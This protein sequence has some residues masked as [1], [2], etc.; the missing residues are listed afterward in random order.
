MRSQNGP[1][2][3]HEGGFSLVEVVFGAVIMA[4]MVGAIGTLFL[5][6]LRVVTLGKARAIGLGLASEKM[7]ALRDLPYDSLSTQN[8]AIYPPG[9]IPD[10]ETVVRDNYTFTVKTEIVYVDDPYDGVENG[11]VST[12]PAAGKPQDLYPYDYKKTQI[13]VKLKSSGAV[14]ST[15][16]TDVAGKAAE[17]SSNTGIL[18]IKVINASGAAI[19][20]ANVSIVNTNPNP[21]VNINTTTDNNGFVIIP[22][23]PPDSSNRYQVIASLGGYSTDGTIP[24]PAGSQTAVE[25][26]PNV[27]AQQITSLTLA[28]DLLSTLYVN[29]VDTSGAAKTS[30]N[31]TTTGAKVIKQNT[32]VYKYTGTTATDGSGNITLSGME[33]DSYSFAVPAGWYIVS[34]SPYAPTALNPNTSKTVNLVVTNDSTWPTIKSISPVSGQTGS[35]AVSIAVTGTNIPSS[36]SLKLKLAGQSDINAT[37][38]TGGGTV[39]TCSLNLTGAVTGAWDVELTKSGNTATQVG[40]FNVVP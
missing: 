2:G 23:L 37:G 17:T 39:L 14:V 28:I 30:F 36:T 4:L 7:E 21:D 10:T 32:T 34:A 13:T 22:K 15:L 5:D 38:C 33:W 9:N 16:T 3:R 29:V 12:G 27:L 20:N 31:V 35:T 24:D 8:G 1:S 26:N 25:L 11:P 6:N 18:S 19:P 40:G